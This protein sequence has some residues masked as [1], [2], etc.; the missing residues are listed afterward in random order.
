MNF[1]KLKKYNFYDKIKPFFFKKKLFLLKVY[2]SLK[3]YFWIK[4]I[5]WKFEEDCLKNVRGDWF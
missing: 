4:I 2:L 1:N 3:Y 5:L